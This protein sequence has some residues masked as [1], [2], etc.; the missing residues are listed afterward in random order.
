MAKDQHIRNCAIH[1]TPNQSSE[2]GQAAI[3]DQ[4]QPSGHPASS[5]TTIALGG[6][7]GGF[8]QTA[9]IGAGSCPQGPTLNFGAQTF[10]VSFLPVC[11]AAGWLGNLLVGLTALA[12]L[13]IVFKGN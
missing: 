13:G 4:A 2:V 1:D 6:Q 7:G 9:L 11:N 3:N 10:A 12:C 5:A 8:D